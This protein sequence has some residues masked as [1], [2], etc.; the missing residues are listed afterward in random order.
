MYTELTTPRSIKLYEDN[1]ALRRRFYTRDDIL[2]AYVSGDY[3]TIQCERGVTYL[4]RTNG[5]LIRRTR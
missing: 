5:E 2:G 3:V 1:G 4:Y